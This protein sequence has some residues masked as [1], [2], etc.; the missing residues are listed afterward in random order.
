M[1]ETPIL[2]SAP[3]V[4]AILAGE[5]TQTRRI[6]KVDEDRLEVSTDS[7]GQQLLMIHGEGCAGACDY[8]CGAVELNCPHGKPGDQLWIRETYYQLGHWEEA[9]GQLTKGGK[10]KQAFIPDS[11][12][13]HFETPS[14]FRK[15]RCWNT[16]DYSI[17]HK[18]LARFMPRS[19]SRTML[20]IVSVRVE[21]LNAINDDDAIAEGV[22]PAP[23]FIPSEDMGI[24]PYTDPEKINWKDGKTA[25]PRARFAA[26]WESI[27]GPGSWS[28]NPWVWVVEFKP[29]N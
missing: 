8:D 20:E 23:Y 15:A 21:R 29:A 17:M 22:N 3:M 1:K 14:Y 13:I 24:I 5:K 2:F 9:K 4:R 25:I 10:Q 12:E 19:A 27:Y 16:P 7:E 6:V 11:D 18:R 28:A 26:L